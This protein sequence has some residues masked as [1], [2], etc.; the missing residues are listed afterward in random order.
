MRASDTVVLVSY[1]ERTFASHMDSLE[2]RF[3]AERDTL[4]RHVGNE[5]HAL[6]SVPAVPEALCNRADLC[7]VAIA[8]A[9]REAKD[10]EITCDDFVR[11]P[12][13]SSQSFSSQSIS[14][15]SL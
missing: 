12:S 7:A 9:F 4:G 13:L 10:H 1:A 6:L 14:S 8:D 5:A 3:V 15:K 2:R 11:H